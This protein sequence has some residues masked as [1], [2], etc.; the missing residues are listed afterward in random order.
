MYPISLVLLLLLL[1][2]PCLGQ[3]TPDSKQNLY[4]IKVLSL[5]KTALTN[6]GVLYALND[7]SISLLTNIKIAKKG[8]VPD[9]K[10]ILTIPVNEIQQISLRKHGSRTRGA[11]I[12]GVLGGLI[13]GLIGNIVYKPCDNTNGSWFGCME[14]FDQRDHVLFGA[15][16][17]LGAGSAVGY[18]ISSTRKYIIFRDQQTYVYLKDSLAAYLYIPPALQS[19]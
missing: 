19:R 8:E 16:L 9:E 13:G 4:I 2:I 5:N 15:F 11:I 12:G 6:N 17:G 18:G 10:D 3:K 7:S 1:N 14:I